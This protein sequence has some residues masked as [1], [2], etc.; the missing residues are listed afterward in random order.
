MLDPPPALCYNHSMDGSREL[1]LKQ[2]SSQHFVPVGWYQN[3]FATDFTMEWHH[4]RQFEIMYCQKGAFAFEYMTTDD[5]KTVERVSVPE[6]CFIFVN[7]GYYHRIS[8]EVNGTQIYNVELLPESCFGEED[9]KLLKS[10]S[11]N[12]R[13][14][15]SSNRQLEE[16]REEDAPFYVLHDSGDVGLTMKSLVEELDANG[17]PAKSLSARLLSLKLLFDIAKCRTSKNAQP[18]KLSYVRNAVQFMQ[19]NFANPVSVKEIAASVELSPAY[20]QR[21]FKA[22]FKKGIHSILTEIR[23][24]NAKNLLQTTSLP[25]QEI[26]KLS[27]FT[28]REQLIYSFRILEGCS[29]YEYRLAYRSK[30]IRAYPWPTD[31]KLLQD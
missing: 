23:V 21:L 4:H 12:V 8:I 27:G 16:M 13:D 1:T 11:P 22:E 28:S 26:A 9:S 20:L 10:L 5:G 29:P 25:N 7:T 14:I 15:F 2:L 17:E 6:K 30:N 18:I 3:M 19:K 24:K 31:T